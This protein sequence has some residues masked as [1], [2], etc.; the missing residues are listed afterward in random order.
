MTIKETGFEGMVELF[1][2]ILPDDRG[3][4][5]ET[6]RDIWIKKA[7]LDF[8]FVQEN[9]S[10]SKKGVLRGIHLQVAPHEQGKLVR[11]AG[12]KVLDVAVDLRKDSSTF[13]KTYACILDSSMHNILMI[14]PG[15]GHGFYVLEEAIFLYK[16]TAYYHKESEIGIRWDDPDLNINWGVDDPIISAKDLA[17]PSFK[18]FCNKL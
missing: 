6:Y 10:F 1:P 3:Y 4:F 8:N 12:G 2:D 9:Q 18:D 11:V 13:G 5:L 17:L 14:P 16:C 7:G 15:F